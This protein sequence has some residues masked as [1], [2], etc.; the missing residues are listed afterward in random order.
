MHP[1]L[2]TI[3]AAD[4]EGQARVALASERA[5]RELNE[6]RSARD[7]S[8]D[9]RRREARDAI[10]AELRAIRSAGDA[11]IA[12]LQRQQDEYLRAL[13]KGGEQRFDE[14]VAAY[15]RIVCEAAS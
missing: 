7:T 9:D 11:R 6:A 1:D 5:D 12:E 10:E 15:L 3:V 2:E 13:A 8:I 4:E 14:A